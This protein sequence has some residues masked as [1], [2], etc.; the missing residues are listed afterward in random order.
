MLRKNKII[1]SLI[2]FAVIFVFIISFCLLGKLDF[3]GI[4][5][6]SE[7]FIGSISK[8]GYSTKDAA[9]RAFVSEELSGNYAAYEYVGYTKIDELSK[10]E[11]TE[12]ND[13]STTDEE[14][15]SGES[16]VIK[17]RNSAVSNNVKS[18]LL[19][20][21]ENYRYYVLPSASGDPV[22]NAYINSV[23]DGE[24]YLNC[25]CTT[26]I[27]LSVMDTMTT[28]LNQIKF[29]DDKAYFKQEVP[30]L[31]SNAYFEE[32]T[33]GLE[34]YLEHPG[35]RDG[36]FYTLS[37]IQS[38]YA[39]DNLYYEL[40]LIKGAEKIPVDELKTIK[41]ITDFAFM[42]NFDASYLV[43]K[44][45]GF[46]ITS[47]GYKAVC[48]ALAGDSLGETFDKVWEDYKVYFRADY[49]VSEG[50]LSKSQTVLRLLYDDNFITLNLTSVYSGFGTT[51][52]EIPERQ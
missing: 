17:Y 14:I 37:E 45:Y 19:E 34:V 36:E 35:K 23:L 24:K 47:N 13:R 7:T 22:T 52:V 31:I 25:T 33:N 51:T 21:A 9:A 12:I 29:D 11:L 26:T 4:E 3:S 42:L 16:V 40:F 5:A 8:M 2:A 20:T 50:R 46:S 27:A 10:S 49:Y 39:K 32:R 18:Y 1:A 41:D 44:N 6:Y 38:Y 15:Q 30:G 43:K 48:K 28:Y